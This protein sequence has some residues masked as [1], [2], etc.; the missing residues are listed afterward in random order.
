MNDEKCGYH[1]IGCNEEFDTSKSDDLGVC[2][3][4]MDNNKDTF[5]IIENPE[6]FKYEFNKLYYTDTFEHWY[7]NIK[8]M[9]FFVKRW[10]LNEFDIKKFIPSIT[11]NGAEIK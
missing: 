8:E 1:C 11:N 6:Q 2:R 7:I 10:K 9:E 5:D 4:C 3:N